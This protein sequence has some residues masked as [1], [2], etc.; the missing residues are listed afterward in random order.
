[1]RLTQTTA[2]LPLCH[3]LLRRLLQVRHYAGEVVYSTTGFIDK[4]KDTIH[5]R[6]GD[7]KKKRG[8]LLEQ[9]ITR[10]SARREVVELLGL[11]ERPLLRHLFHPD[12]SHSVTTTSAA[13]AAV[14]HVAKMSNTVSA[15]FKA[16]LQELLVLIRTT[17][18][19]YVRCLKPN[20]NQVR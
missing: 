9:H 12:H 15:Q 10:P 1:M 5:R 14:P 3:Q 11:S 7:Q 17:T 13:G 16:Q 8:F 20:G 2:R 4:N 18:P 19:H 6:A